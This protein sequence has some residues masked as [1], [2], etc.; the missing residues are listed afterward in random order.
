MA[1]KPIVPSKLQELRK[2]REKE[3]KKR[4]NFFPSLIITLA[5]WF[6]LTITILFVD[7]TQR[8]ALEIFFTLLFLALLFTF[9]LLLINTRRGFIVSIATT[10]FSV[11]LYLGVGNLFN[12]LLIVGASSM[13]E[14]YFT[15][16]K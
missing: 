2:L 6:L 10:L 12:L 1:G 5:L 3:I 13:F 16:R 11:L 15:K 8:W 9:S 7:P 4:K 14:I